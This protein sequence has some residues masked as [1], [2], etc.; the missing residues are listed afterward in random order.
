[1]DTLRVVESQGSFM[2][3]RKL[4]QTQKK[5][6]IYACHEKKNLTLMTLGHYAMSALYFAYVIDYEMIILALQP[7]YGFPNYELQHF[8]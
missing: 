8:Y 6:P 3:W 7:N 5:L 1:M 2:S 4:A